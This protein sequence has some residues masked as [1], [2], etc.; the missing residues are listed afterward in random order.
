MISKERKNAK[1]RDIPEIYQDLD[2]IIEREREGGYWRACEKV[3]DEDCHECLYEAFGLGYLF[4]P[5][6]SKL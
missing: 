4:L 5:H 3:C 1:L 6:H 2:K